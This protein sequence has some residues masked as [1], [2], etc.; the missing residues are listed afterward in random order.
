M[1]LNGQ[2][3]EKFNMFKYQ[4]LILCK[5]G[6]TEGGTWERALQG[7]GRIIRLY[8]EK[9]TLNMELKKVTVG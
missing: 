4:G 5:N 3:M 8:D 6:V 7:S 9:G 1:K 2:V